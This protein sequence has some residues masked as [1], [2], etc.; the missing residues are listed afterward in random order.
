VG[1]SC[2]RDGFVRSSLPAHRDPVRVSS[3]CGRPQWPSS[4]VSASANETPART[5]ISAVFSMPSF[6][7]IWSAVRKPIADVAGQAVGVLR[8]ELNGISA[9]GLVDADRTRRA[10]AVAVQKQH[11]LANHLLLCPARDFVLNWRR[12]TTDHT[13]LACHLIDAQCMTATPAQAGPAPWFCWKGGMSAKEEPRRPARGCYGAFWR[14]PNL[15]RQTGDFN[16]CPL[17]VP[18]R[19][20]HPGH[21]TRMWRI[22]SR[23]FRESTNAVWSPGWAASSRPR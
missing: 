19:L 7:A 6:A 2:F 20:S 4:I 17:A 12:V 16:V 13:L 14:S 21:T 3:S 9:V 1:I 5:R 10:D 8:N 11:D 22:I 23:S 18:F 15:Y